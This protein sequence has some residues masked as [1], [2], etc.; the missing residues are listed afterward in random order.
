MIL[1]VLVFFVIGLALGSFINEQLVRFAPKTKLKFSWRSVCENCGHSL[2]WWQ[3]AP[4]ISHFILRGKCFFCRRRIPKI[5][6]WIEIGVGLTTALL[7]WRFGDLG[8]LQQASGVNF[9]EAWHD[10][11]VF[12][13]ALLF[14]LVLWFAALYDWR[15]MV[16]PDWLTLPAILAAFV[17]RLHIVGPDQW[18]SLL[19][20]GVVPAAAFTFL[21]FC[22]RGKWMGG[23]DIRL[24]ALI[25]LLL[26]WR[27]IVVAFVL[28]F[29]FGALLGVILMIAKK[30]T[31]K[32]E[33]PYAPFLVFSA[34]VAVIFG[35][36]LFSWY[37]GLFI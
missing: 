5:Y 26:S 24:A 16:L 27:L 19:L 13:G 37:V 31:R 4:L 28:S 34:L 3:L 11:S 20:H 22:S 12:L 17:G 6:I 21:V 15:H 10:N 2:P 1:G 7:F 14:S 35:E 8:V 29:F 36:Q 30:A 25:G 33:L 23:G 18:P 32:T 9:I